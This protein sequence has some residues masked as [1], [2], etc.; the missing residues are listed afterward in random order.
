MSSMCSSRALPSAPHGLPHPW[1]ALDD[2]KPS[3]RLHLETCNLKDLS[4]RNVLFRQEGPWRGRAFTAHARL[5]MPA[6]Q[7]MS[8]STFPGKWLEVVERVQECYCRRRNL[9]G[10]SVSY[11]NGHFD[12]FSMSDMLSKCLG[13]DFLF[14]HIQTANNFWFSYFPPNLYH[15]SSFA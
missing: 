8:Q 1:A 10:L 15:I 6:H 7:G 13:T 12:N 4:V 11:I 3:G 2:H 14:F 5:L 9:E